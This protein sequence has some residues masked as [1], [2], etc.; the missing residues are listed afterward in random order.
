M[1]KKDHAAR[2][3]SDEGAEMDIAGGSDPARRTAGQHARAVVERLRLRTLAALGVLAVATALLGRTFGLKD[4]RFLGS[5]VALLATIFVV[6]RYVLPLLA[7]RD[8]GATGEE[9]VGTLLEELPRE[10]WRVIH[11]ATLGRGN[12]D[13]IVIG[14]PGVFTIETKSRPEP[15]QVRNVHGA[16]LRQAHAQR[17]AIEQ[18]AGVRVEP[19]VVFSRAWVDRP[20]AT[21]KGVRIVPARML[22]GYLS[23]RQPMLPAQGIEFVSA[24]IGT[25]LAEHASAQRGGAVVGRP[26][27]GSSRTGGRATLR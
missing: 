3:R 7:R 5:E 13:H 21:R 10:R 14:P 26:G 2:E 4:V 11:D 25:A 17:R 16:I 12:V 8:R 15:V 1:S 23:K 18:V 19:L 22:V 24:R 27:A 20:L 6:W 9:E